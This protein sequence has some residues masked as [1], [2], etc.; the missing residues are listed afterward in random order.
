MKE[1]HNKPREKRLKEIIIGQGVVTLIIVVVSL[2]LVFWGFVYKINWQNFSIRHTGIIYLSFSPKDAH[3]FINDDEKPG[4]APFNIALFPGYYETRLTK[5]GF[6][7]W[8]KNIKVEADKVHSCRNIV[9][10]RENP[11]LEVIIDKDQVALIDAPYDILVKNPAGDLSAN[12]YEIW[13]G[14]KL[15]S[16]F[17]KPISGVIW[18]PGNEY[19]AFQQG[20]EIRVIEQDGFN[21]TLLVQLSSSAPT[22]FLFSWDGSTLLYKD[23]NEYKKAAIN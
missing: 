10:F 13:N 12:E 15:V 17:S 3:V 22:K 9:L 16:R 5:D 18:Y 8:Y 2:Y 6:K 14:D 19:I 1:Y 21:D 23:G 11:E 20:N 7:S 4:S